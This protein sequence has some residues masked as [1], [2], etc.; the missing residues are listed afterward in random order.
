MNPAKPLVSEVVPTE[1]PIEKPSRS[2]PE[3][4]PAKKKKEFPWE[5]ILIVAGIFGIGYG[6]AQVK[7]AKK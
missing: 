5:G 7:G 4:G 6:L 3:L 1:K 2:E